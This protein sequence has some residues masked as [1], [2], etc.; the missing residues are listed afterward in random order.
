[1]VTHA[2]D[3]V[4]HFLDFFILALLAFRTFT[5][6]SL[7]FFQVKAG[8]KAVGFSLLYGVFLEWAQWSVPGRDASFWDGTADALGV[9]A[10]SG[11]FRISQ[12]TLSP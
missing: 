3:K 12:L 2:N 5:L 1:M 8:R 4:L 7:P 9:L 6:S 11:I 10:A